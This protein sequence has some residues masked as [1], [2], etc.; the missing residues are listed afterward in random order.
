MASKLVKNATAPTPRVAV[1]MMVTR[2]AWKRRSHASAACT[3][4]STMLRIG[5]LVDVGVPLA[6]AG[7]GAAGGAVGWVVGMAGAPWV[8][9][10]WGRGR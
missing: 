1:A 10:W 5:S 6:W 3:L 4:G 7:A 2:A 9:G 8:S